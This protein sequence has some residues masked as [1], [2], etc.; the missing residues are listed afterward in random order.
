MANHLTFQERQFLYRLK[1]KGKTNPEIAELM[2]RDR[3]TIHRELKRNMG[4]RGYRPKQAQRLAEE[5][6]LASRRPHKMDEPDVHQ[7]V[8]D[9]LEKCWSPEQI[10]GRVQCDYPRAPARWLSRQTIYDWIE[11]RAPEWQ[12]LLRRGGR[13]PEKRGKLTDCVRIDGRPDV[14]NRRRRYG[15]WEGD[16]IVGKSRHSALVTLV[17]R[18]SGYVRIGRVDS[19]KSDRTMRVAK[20]RMKD[21]PSALRRSMTFDNGKEFAEHR[22]LTRELGLDVYFADPY[23]SWQRGTNENM[24]GLLRQFFPKGTDFTQ[25]SH[26]KVACVEQLINERPRKRLGYRTP[27]EILAPRICCN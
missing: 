27:A 19:M 25:I 24:N 13:P 4:Q 11:S 16:T 18:K 3:S 9:R 14:I 15:D 26:R 7:Y 6:R 8:Q 10:A 5:R 17:E 22:R 21:L 12:R 23:A 1:R 2:G 20:R